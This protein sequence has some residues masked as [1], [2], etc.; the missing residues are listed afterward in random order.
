MGKMNE[1]WEKYRDKEEYGR[2]TL[3]RGGFPKYRERD[4]R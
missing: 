1:E 4:A 2:G 3:F